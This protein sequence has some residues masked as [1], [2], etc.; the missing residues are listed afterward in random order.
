[1]FFFYQL[2]FKPKWYVRRLIKAG[3][4]VGVGKCKSFNISIGSKPQ[5][6]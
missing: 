4:I 6:N 1:M 3:K 5:I 2:Y